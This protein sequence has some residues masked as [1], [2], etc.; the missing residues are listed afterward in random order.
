MIS[1]SFNFEKIVSAGSMGQVVL[2]L[3]GKHKTLN[4][5]MSTT[6]EKEKRKMESMNTE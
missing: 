4:S 2:H 5:N 6:K 1:T 3:P